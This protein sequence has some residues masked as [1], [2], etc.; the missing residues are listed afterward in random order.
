MAYGTLFLNG[1]E[2]ETTFGLTVSSFVGGQAGSGRRLA[3]RAAGGI[4]GGP[5]RAISLLDI[6]QMAGSFD[7]GIPFSEDTRGIVVNCFI[8]AS[9][10]TTL[11]AALDAIK[12]AC[13]T[14]LVEIR[15]AYSATRAFYGVLETPDINAFTDSILNGR[16]SGILAFTCPLP[17][18]IALAPNTYS[19]GAT[20]VD[21]PLGTAPSGLRDQWSA[22]I[23]I[24]GAST[25]PTLSYYNKNGDVVSTMAFTYSPLAGDLIRVDLGRKRVRRVVSGVESNCMPFLVAPYA[26]AA[27]DPGDGLIRSAQYPKLSVSSGTASIRLFQAWR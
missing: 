1:Q 9:D 25:T 6:P 20:P 18:A 16:A 19:F 3:A 27:L 26:F 15:T 13:G 21:I 12:E 14:G 10:Y 7:P 8:N 2:T 5:S 24:V 4:L 22:M 23:E 17:Y 11:N